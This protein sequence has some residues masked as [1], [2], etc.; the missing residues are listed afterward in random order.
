MAGLILIPAQRECHAPESPWPL[1][2]RRGGVLVRSASTPPSSTREQG[3]EI[4]EEQACINTRKS[5]FDKLTQDRFAAF[6]RTIKK[7]RVCRTAVY[8]G[9]AVV[10]CRDSKCSRSWPF[11]LESVVMRDTDL[12]HSEF[13]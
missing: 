8:I 9:T 13:D 5:L 6:A 7:H 10:L 11:A 2:R 4:P 3:L 12:T 1:T